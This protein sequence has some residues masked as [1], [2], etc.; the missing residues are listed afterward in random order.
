M[1]LLA[2]SLVFALSGQVSEIALYNPSFE[3][4]PRH[5]LPP[6]GWID[7]GFPGETPPDVQ[8]SGAWEVYRPAYHGNT[9]LGMVTR[10]N[11]TWESVGQR[12][13]SPLLKGKCYN[14]SMYM[15]MSSEYWSQVVPDSIK[16]VELSDEERNTL[17][18]KNFDRPIQ[19]RIWGGTGYC[20]K[21]QLLAVSEPV[22]NTYWEKY[23][24]RFEPEIDVTH[25]VLE[26]Y[27]N[28]PTLFAYNGNLLMDH[29][30]TITLTA[31]D[32]EE[33]IV[34]AP[35]VQILQPIEKIDIARHQVRV[36]ASVRN[37]TSSNQVTFKVN[38]SNIEVFDFEPGRGDFNTEVFLQPGRNTIYLHGE[39]SAGEAFDETSVYIPVI[40]K[41][42]AETTA[43]PPSEP[44]PAA[45]APEPEYTLMPELRAVDPKPGQIFKIQGLSFKADSSRIED[46]SQEVLD[47]LHKFLVHHPKVSVEIGGHTNGIPKHDFCDRL[48]KARAQSVADYLAEKGISKSRLISKGYGKRDPIATNS[49]REGRLKNQRVEIKILSTS[50]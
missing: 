34:I 38:D 48:S 42:V 39:N 24:F 1:T 4:I 16:N 50:S 13:T 46:E 47:E 14:F 30:S 11:D 37:L 22:A 40:E 17:P 25:I 20:T 7:C 12:L 10:E 15:C 28:T 27:Y 9:Y 5:S 23:E 33:P 44:E 21:H 8:P 43:P 26:A 31:C 2:T 36:K 6:R 19:L 45:V 3:D 35:A 49:T 32:G 18:Q 41:P 29:S